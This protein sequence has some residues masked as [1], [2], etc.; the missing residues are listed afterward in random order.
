MKKPG[1]IFLLFLVIIIEG[2]VVLSSELLAIRQTIPFVG[3]G[4]DTVSIIIAA[5]LMP[6]AFGYHSGGRF[7]PRPFFGQFMTVRKK[8]VF[9]I[10]VA[11]VFLLIGLSYIPL[12][13]F[14]VGMIDLGISHRVLM[15]T[16]YSLLFLVIPVYLLGQTIPLVSNFFSQ[17]KLSEITGRMLFFST[18]GSFLGAIFSTLVLMS[19]AG[20]HYTAALNFV[21]LAFL[22]IVLNK[23]INSR[24]SIIVLLIAA[25]GIYINSGDLMK[26]LSIVENNKYNT[27][28]VME[29]ED[30]TRHMSLNNN[31]SSMYREDGKKHDYIAYAEKIFIDPIREADPPKDILVIGAGGFTFGLEDRTNNYE[32]LDIDPSLK[33]VSEE[34]FLQQKLSDNKIFH[35]VPARA[36]LTGNKKKYD[37]ILL[38]VYLGDTS[39]P[40]HMVTQEFFQQVRGALEEN[41]IL[42][43]NMIVSPTFAS[44]FSRHIDNTL[45]SVFPF[46]TRQVVDEYN[47]WTS[48]N[49]RRNNLLYIYHH[50]PDAGSDTIYTD[51]K[52]GMFFDKPKKRVTE[53]GDKHVEEERE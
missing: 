9:N 31:D 15:T 2:Y 10:T 42:A 44:R 40:E 4:T 17:E 22:V 39:I 6:L 46:L 34:H 43:I 35:P 48:E 51:N 7:V 23:D 32:Y 49:Y 38:D 5:V 45:R 20:V 53:P 37:L 11:S 13:L 8:L 33:R 21:L 27:I 52:N 1:H 14:F 25:C 50:R 19:F 30:G 18:L 41:G 12:S 29:D 28:V 36:F 26:S 47:G 3:S 16:I 24:S